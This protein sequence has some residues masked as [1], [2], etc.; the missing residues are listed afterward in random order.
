[1]ALSERFEQ[2]FL[3]ASNLHR[4]QKRKGS[5][6]PYLAHLLGA[7]SLVLEDG[8]SE[9]EAIAALLHDAPEDQGGLEVLEE[10]RRRFGEQVAMIVDGCTD[11]YENPKPP[12]RLRKESFL[13]RLAESAQGVQRVALADKVHNA[14]SL[15]ADLRRSGEKVW[16]RFNGGKEGTLWYYRSLVEVYRGLPPTAMFASFEETVLKIEALADR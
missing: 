6:T 9:D 15:L 2:A 12:W 11:S 10:I 3:Y 5:S 7:A 8:G 14:R 1:M 16:A 13:E 4:N